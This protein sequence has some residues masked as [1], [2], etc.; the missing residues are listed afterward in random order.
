MSG[1]Q[2]VNDIWDFSILYCHLAGPQTADFAEI[3]KGELRPANRPEHMSLIVS[4]S[5]AV[6]FTK[7]SPR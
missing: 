4:L 5:G 2:S 3:G 6:A 1:T 7:G